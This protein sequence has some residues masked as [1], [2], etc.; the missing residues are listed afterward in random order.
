V[1][2]LGRL[3]DQLTALTDSDAEFEDD[4]TF[5]AELNAVAEVAKLYKETW[6]GNSAWGNAMDDVIY[7][8]RKWLLGPVMCGDG[9]PVALDDEHSAVFS[10][11]DE[12]HGQASTFDHNR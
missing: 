8:V 5:E 11:I 9:D 10:D 1:T 7:E 6:P 2:V 12:L 3:N 4:E